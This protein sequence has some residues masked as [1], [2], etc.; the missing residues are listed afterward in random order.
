[1]NIASV[2]RTNTFTREV[3]KENRVPFLERAVLTE[4]DGSLNFDA[5]RKPT[6]KRTSDIKQ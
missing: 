2:N 5:Y 1:M 3:T 6:H 4:D